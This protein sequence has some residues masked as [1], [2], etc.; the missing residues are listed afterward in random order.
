MIRRPPRSTLFPYTTLFRSTAAPAGE[1]SSVETLSPSLRRTDASSAGATGS[2]RGTGLMLRSEEDT[3][4]LHSPPQL[5][6][7]L[8]PEKKKTRTFLR[9]VI[10]RTHLRVPVA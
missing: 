10:E 5:L 7:R 8:L 1:M 3:A 6:C 9:S 2:P 4:E